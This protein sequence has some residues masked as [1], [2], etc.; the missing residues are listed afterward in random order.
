MSLWP[1]INHGGRSKRTLKPDEQQPLPPTVVV[2]NVN[3]NIN[4]V[5][6]NTVSPFCSPVDVLVLALQEGVESGSSILL[7]ELEATS[8]IV[9]GLGGG[10]VRFWQERGFSPKFLRM[11][12][13]TNGI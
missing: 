4:V 11:S 1:T 7:P 12:T 2:N 9:M 5:V 6:I 13:F 10:G 3:V 8:L